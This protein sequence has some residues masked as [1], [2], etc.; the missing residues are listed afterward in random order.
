M[1][2]IKQ[3]EKGDFGI[4]G[5]PD[6]GVGFVNVSFSYDSNRDNKDMFVAGRDF[7]VKNITVRPKVAGTDTAAVTLAVKKCSSGGTDTAG[8]ALHSAT[9][10][11]KGTIN[12]PQQIAVTSAANRLLRGY[13]LTLDATGT[14]T[15]AKGV[16]TVLLAPA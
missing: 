2:N 4:E 13:S 10:D 16:V 7:V 8:T 3:G 11:L 14:T 5:E 9:I 1:A 15:A 6:Y 12:T